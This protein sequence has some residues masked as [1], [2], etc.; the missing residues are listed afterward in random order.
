[1]AKANIITRTIPTRTPAIAVADGFA[2]RGRVV[3]VIMP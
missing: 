2:A 1:M 3:E